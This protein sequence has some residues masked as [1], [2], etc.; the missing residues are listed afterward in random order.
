MR[1]CVFTVE[2]FNYEGLCKALE[3]LFDFEKKANSRV[4]QSGVLQGLNL[5]DITRAGQRLILKDGCTGCFKKILHDLKGS[6]NVLSYCW[7]GHFI[8]SA[9]SS[10]II[11]IL[12]QHC[13]SGI[14]LAT[15]VYLSIILSLVS[16]QLKFCFP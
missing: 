7:C 8:R 16:T 5:E 6:V 3:L 15:N 12:E 10:G 1:T 13:M 14:V 2:E 9:F 11:F 4:V